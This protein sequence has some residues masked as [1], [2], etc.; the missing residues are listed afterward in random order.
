MDRLDADWQ[1][2]SK[3]TTR[4]DTFSLHLLQISPVASS[5]VLPGMLCGGCDVNFGAA[6]GEGVLAVLASKLHRHATTRKAR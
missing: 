5:V 1:S 3:R 6:V 2:G 4:T